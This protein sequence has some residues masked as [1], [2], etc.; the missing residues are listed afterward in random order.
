MAG[1]RFARALV[2]G[3][4]SGIGTSFA[5]RLAAEGA[6]LVLVAR[7]EDRLEALADQLRAS[8]GV[9]VE[10]LAADLADPAQLAEVESRVAATASPIELLVNNA[11]FRLRRRTSAPCRSRTRRPSWP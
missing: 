8:H 6:D 2:T 11:G 9:A 1:R 10:V 4:S 3:A 5:R 7:S